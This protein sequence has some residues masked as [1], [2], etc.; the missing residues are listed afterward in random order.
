VDKILIWD[1]GSDDLT[2][3]IIKEIIKKYPNKVMFKQVGKV[4][5]EGYTKAKQEML[6]ETNSDWIIIVDGDE[7]WWE[8]SIRKVAETIQKEGSSLETIVN[9]FSNVIGDIYHY[10]EEMAGRYEIDG[11]RGHL[12][13]RATNRR[14]PGLHM[15]KPHGQQGMF[16]ENGRLIQERPR[17]KRKHINEFAYLHFTHVTR[18]FSKAQDFLVPKRAIKLKHEIGKSF[19]LDFYYPEAFFRERPPIIPSPWE[20]MSPRFLL[21]AQALTLPRKVK[22]RVVKGPS[23]Y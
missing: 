22:R 6:N 3:E 15:A 12:Q 21:K 14:I 23:G 16:D 17:K 19:P 5:P 10:Q 2:V 1:T 20:K 4:D 9:H 8:E 11:R 7:V 18:S 13:I